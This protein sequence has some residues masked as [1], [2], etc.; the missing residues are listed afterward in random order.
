MHRRFPR[1]GVVL[2]VLLSLGQWPATALAAPPPEVPDGVRAFSIIPPGQSGFAN[3]GQIASGQIGPHV[4]DQREMYAALVDDDDVTEDE[5]S[6]YFHSGQFGPGEDIEREYSPRPGATV[7]RDAFGIPHVYGVTDADAAFALGYVS[8]EDRLF[9]MDVLRHAARGD[10]ASFLGPEYADYDAGLRREGYTQAEVQAMLD[11]IVE[12]FGADGLLLQQLLEAY[13]EGVNA[14]MEE[15]RDNAALNPVEYDSRQLPLEDWAP[16]DTVYMAILQLRQFGETAGQELQNAAALRELQA[17]LGKKAGKAAFRD[18]LWHNDKNSYPTIPPEDGTFPSQDLGQVDQD[19]VAIP[20]GIRDLVRTLSRSA[21][22]T[23]RVSSAF[24]WKMPASNFVAVA[25][26]RSTTGNSLQFGAPQVGYTVPQFFMDIDV[27]S[28]SFDFRGPALPGAS[29]L[30]PLGRGID[31]AWS[32]T[33]GYSDAVD[34]RIEK[35]CDGGYLFNGTCEPFE[36]RTETIEV[37]GGEPREETIERS[38]HGPVIARGTVGGEPVAIVKERAFWMHEADTVIAFMRLGK[39]TM[40][41][42]T[43]FHEALSVATMSFNAVYADPDGIAYHH[44][45]EYPLRTDGVDPMLPSWGTG[46]WE[47][48]GTVP[49]EQL[50]NVTDPAQGWLVNWNNQP[51]RAW[52]NG[53]STYWG[54]THRVKVLAQQMER[55]TRSSGTLSLSDVVDVIRKAAVMDGHGALLGPRMMR[56]VGDPGGTRGAA[57]DAIQAWMEAD[58]PRTDTDRNRRT[59]AGTAVA[60]FDSWYDKLSHR[61]FDD[62]FAGLYDLGLQLSDSPGPGGGGYYSDFSNMLWNLF[63]SSTRGSMSRNYCDDRGT[64]AKETCA[65]QVRKSLRQA[66]AGLTRRF[67]S[68]LSKWRSP[69]DYIVF[70]EVGA[71]GVD[72]IPWQNRGTYN[73]AIEVTGI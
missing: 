54:P 55:L 31:Y 69:A 73:H 2:I 41:D 21:R 33:T 53:D 35:L 50:P 65:Q 68:N 52:A 30:I 18:V 27:H 64:G 62:E 29:L 3:L 37:R 72:P 6:N 49:Y 28:P 4:D 38:I 25:P 23:Q 56:L 59:D 1:V 61:V 57:L 42:A 16:T 5:L 8:A 40:Q 15:V 13:S 43:D 10:L 58:A 45:G 12:D 22:E 48:T 19:A 11:G 36:T 26:E 70:S 67:G 14:W 32:L 24:R 44:V 39:N 66:V 47:W 20:D 71:L 7:Y 60:A 17:K 34:V 46:E 63:G 9:Q 51:A